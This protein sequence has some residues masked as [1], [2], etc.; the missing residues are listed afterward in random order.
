MN[1]KFRKSRGKSSNIAKV[2]FAELSPKVI[3]EYND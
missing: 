1:I 3:E 2:D